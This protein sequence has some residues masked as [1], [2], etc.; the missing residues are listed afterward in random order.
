[1]NVE[2]FLDIV[3]WL[4][5]AG[6]VLLVLL[7]GK[8]AAAHMASRSSEPDEQVPLDGMYGQTYVQG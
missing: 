4:A 8:H 3:L 7:D 6:V 5:I 1:M 2:K